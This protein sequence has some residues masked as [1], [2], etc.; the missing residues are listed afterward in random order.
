[1]WLPGNIVVIDESVYEFTGSSPCHV[2]IPRKP[3]PNGLLSY[4]L[5]LYTAELKLPVLFDLEPHVPSNMLSAR[6][7]AKR[8]VGRLLTSHGNSIRPHV[9]MDSAFGSFTDL[10]YYISKGV[11]C[12]FSMSSKE[13]PWLWDMLSWQCPLDAGRVALL[14][15]E[16]PDHHILA[17]CYHVL[18]ESGK[19]IDIRT[20]TTGFGWEKPDILEP[21][22]SKIGEHRLDPNGLFEY[23]THWADGDI[24]WQHSSSFMDSDGT[25]TDIWLEQAKEDDIADALGDL[26]AEQL[27]AICE[28]KSWK[29]SGNKQ[30]LTKRIVKKTLAYKSD[31]YEWTTTLMEATLGTAAAG[32]ASNCGRI[33]RYYTNTYKALDRFDQMWY[34]IQYSKRDRSWA[35]CYTWA[36]IVDCVLN[37]RS[38]YCELVGKIEPVKVFTNEL[39]SEIRNFVK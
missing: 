2:Y 9:V 39:I 10:D 36:V 24:T 34:D 7:S 17:S 38:A 20:A 3:H 30:K 11:V 27:I 4:G 37:A 12:T 31:D 35:T 19:I 25:F 1:M 23:E 21:R 15:M 6:D 26:T 13:R 28:S 5:S 22:V 29:K 16:T 18:S 14:P 33:R 8:L 32:E